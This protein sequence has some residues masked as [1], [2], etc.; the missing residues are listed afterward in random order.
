M[1]IFGMGKKRN[2]PKRWGSRSLLYLQKDLAGLKEEE[3]ELLIEKRGDR[4]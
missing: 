3:R 2:V 1:Y 4:A